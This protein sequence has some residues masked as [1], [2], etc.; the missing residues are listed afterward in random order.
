MKY[1][2]L[3]GL[4]VLLFPQ[5]ALAYDDL[6]IDVANSP[7]T[8]TEFKA[9]YYAGSGNYPRPSV[10]YYVTVN[11]NSDKK[12]VAYKI[13]FMAF[14]AFK[15][16]LGRGLNGY[17]IDVIPPGGMMSSGWE[18]SLVEAGLFQSYGMGVAYPTKVRFEDGTIWEA[19]T[20]EVL[21]ELRKIESG[22]TIEDLSPKKE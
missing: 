12:V 15:D 3:G 14:D 22:L 10:N 13:G 1:S 6:V 7:I 16:A 5:L 21:Q 20:A 19:D 9:T 17:A 2:I 4:A 8:L 11:N 18:H